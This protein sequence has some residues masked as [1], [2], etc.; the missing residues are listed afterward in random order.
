MHVNMKCFAVTI[1][2]FNTE[3]LHVCSPRYIAFTEVHFFF[4][5]EEFYQSNSRLPEIVSFAHEH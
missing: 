2:K 3:V 4:I 5:W 1:I